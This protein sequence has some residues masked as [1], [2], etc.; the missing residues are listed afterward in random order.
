MVVPPHR[1]G[2]QA[3]YIAAPLPRTGDDDLAA[4]QQWALEHLAEDLGVDR[5][6]RR[7]CTS[8][9]TLT[10]R[11]QDACGTSPAAWVARQRLQR[12]QEL[13]ETTDLPVEAVAAAVGWGT[14]AVLRHHFAKLGTSPLAYR[15]TFAA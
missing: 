6:A 13:L 5:L 14:A 7:A 10:R 9:R 3:Q 11:F 2:G 1:D 15:R 12:A 8:T 4:L